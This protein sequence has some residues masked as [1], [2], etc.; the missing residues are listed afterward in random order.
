MPRQILTNPPKKGTYGFNKTTLGE[1]LGKGGAA[2]EYNYVSSPYEADRKAKYE[3]MLA[4][5]AK[6]PTPNAFRPPN[7]TKKGG[8]VTAG[9]DTRGVRVRAGGGSSDLAER[10]E[11]R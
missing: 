11:R 9:R 4:G 3:E 10:V 6:Q 8:C 5:K 7:P 2:G 1:R